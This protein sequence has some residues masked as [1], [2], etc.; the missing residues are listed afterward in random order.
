MASIR[1]ELLI[2]SRAEHVWDAVRDFG[3]LHQRL[4]PGFVVDAKMAGAA[5]IVTFA[6]GKVA[7]EVLVDIDD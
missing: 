1:K 3:A 7:R 4:V 2:A 5:R 6:N